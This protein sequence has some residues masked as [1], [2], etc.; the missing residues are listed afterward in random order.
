MQY[1]IF[2]VKVCLAGPVVAYVAQEMSRFYSGGRILYPGS[3]VPNLFSL[4]NRLFSWKEIVA[5][6]CLC[7][8]LAV[9]AVVCFL[10]FVAAHIRAV[11]TLWKWLTRLHPLIYLGF[12]LF[13]QSRCLCHRCF[14]Y[15]FACRLIYLDLP[16]SNDVECRQSGFYT[17][18]CW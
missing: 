10:F 16:L 8:C 9:V 6:F 17:V 14:L 11:P 3:R 13:H 12:I 15:Q 18:L 2:I 4:S 1:E 7:L 5:F